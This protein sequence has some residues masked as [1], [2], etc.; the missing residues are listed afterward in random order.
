MHASSLKKANIALLSV[1]GFLWISCSSEPPCTGKQNFTID[2]SSGGGF[3]G[4]VNG[5]TITCTGTAI[6]WKRF[7]SSERRT[8]DS[9]KLDETKFRDLADLMEEEELLSYKNTFSGNFVA[10]LTI[11]MGTQRSEISYD[12]TALPMD[13]P[14]SVRNLITELQSIHKPSGE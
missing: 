8:T 2:F 14:A 1:F 3:T 7:P 10:Y 4:E 9:L 11:Q 13:M 5:M 6:F 12:P